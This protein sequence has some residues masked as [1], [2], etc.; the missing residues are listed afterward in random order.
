MTNRLEILN[1]ISTRLQKSLF[2]LS[3]IV[4]LLHVTQL[5]KKKIEILS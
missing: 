3:E 4:F 2:L 5:S 1:Y